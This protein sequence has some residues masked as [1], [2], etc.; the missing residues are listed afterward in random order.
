MNVRENSVGIELTLTGNSENIFNSSTL[1][2]G[3][4]NVYGSTN[5]G[6]QY[7]KAINMSL[8]AF[9]NVIVNI[10]EGE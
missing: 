10:S 8:N 6:G 7:R 2:V 9:P 1:K 3:T 4:I 5:T